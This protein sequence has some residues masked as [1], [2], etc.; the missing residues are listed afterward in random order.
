MQS[1]GLEQNF[2]AFFKDIQPA[3]ERDQNHAKRLGY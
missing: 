3:K 2:M 1:S